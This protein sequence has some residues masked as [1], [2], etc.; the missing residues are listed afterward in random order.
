MRCCRD[1]DFVR[2]HSDPALYMR[3]YG[4]CIIWVGDLLVFTTADV[5]K[6]P[7]DQMRAQFKRRTQDELGHVL[8]MEIMRDRP[9]RTMTI[10]QLKIKKLL[11][12][13]GMQR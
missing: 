2:Y 12:E 11:E 1:L 10:T 8:G 6:P 7:C 13:N 9:N 3:R 4:R 5:M